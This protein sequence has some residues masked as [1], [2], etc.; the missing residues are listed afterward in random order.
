MPGA[1]GRQDDCF[2]FVEIGRRGVLLQVQNQIDAMQL[3]HDHKCMMSC[4]TTGISGWSASDHFQACPLAVEGK[5]HDGQTCHAPVL[6][7][8]SHMTVTQAPVTEILE[9]AEP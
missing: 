5:H 4:P 1:P 6:I 3:Y 9:P 7:R 8:Y 2:V